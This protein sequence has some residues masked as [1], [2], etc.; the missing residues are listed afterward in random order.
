MLTDNTSEELELMHWMGLI[1]S[2]KINCAKYGLLGIHVENVKLQ[3]LTNIFGLKWSIVS[4]QH[5][6][7]YLFASGP[8]MQLQHLVLERFEL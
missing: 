8:S 4:A 5:V 3:A 2:M 1:S 6:N 7:G